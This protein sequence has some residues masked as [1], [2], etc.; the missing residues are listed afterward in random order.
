MKKSLE[1][2]L[3][4][5]T[6]ILLLNVTNLTSTYGLFDEIQEPKNTT[7]RYFDFSG[8]RKTTDSPYI[9]SSYDSNL[10]EMN[11]N[12]ASNA[13]SESEIFHINFPST[14]TNFVC[15]IEFNY[16]YTGGMLTG[17]YVILGSTHNEIGKVAEANTLCSAAIWDPWSTSS[18][19]YSI[20]VNGF[21]DDTRTK[22]TIFREGTIT[23]EFVRTNSQLSITIKKE[24]VIKQS[25]TWNIDSDGLTRDLDYLRVYL[26]VNPSYIASTS[27][28]FTSINLVLTDSSPN[29][30]GS[31]NESL[32]N[33]KVG[34]A[35]GSTILIVGLIGGIT[36]L[37]IRRKREIPTTKEQKSVKPQDELLISKSQENG[38]IKNEETPSSKSESIAYSWQIEEKEQ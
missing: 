1:R 34:I 15:E 5:I 38:F 36:F 20:R 31:I 6:L 16:I 32:N 24:G 13:D 12:Y 33:T 8:F 14:I 7:I 17:I 28:H 23:T 11:A 3:I 27:V 4:T 29:S 2:K 10:I 26:N 25:G 21:I 30:E 18:G 37:T 9:S 22:E 19:V 35:V